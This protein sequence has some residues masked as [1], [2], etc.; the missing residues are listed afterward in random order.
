MPADLRVARCRR[1][2]IRLWE[3]DYRRDGAYFL[4]ICTHSRKTLF[5]VVCNSRVRLTAAGNAVRECWQA[6]PD[7]FPRVSLDRF[8][9]MPDHIHG[10]LVIGGESSAE[11]GR[12][13]PIAD[14]QSGIVGARHAVPLHDPAARSACVPTVRP[15]F[16]RPIPGSLATIIGA[17][18]SAVTRRLRATGLGSQ[19][20]QRNYYEHVI[21]NDDD[22][23]AI[24]RYI[25][26]NPMRW[27]NRPTNM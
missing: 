27:T 19:V 17:F 3:Y 11:N 6:I 2:S 15:A 12:V 7:H 25:V 22:L 18:K 4:T 23:R 14:D 1:R 20:W 9:I 10:I 8:L 16:G 24:R 21:R 26:T 13:Q 5:G